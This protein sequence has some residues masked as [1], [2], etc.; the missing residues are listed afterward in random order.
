MCTCPMLKRVLYAC[1]RNTYWT[2]LVTGNTY[3]LLT[4]SFGLNISVVHFRHMPSEKYALWSGK[5]DLCCEPSSC[6]SYICSPILP[7]GCVL[8][9]LLVHF[10]HMLSE[11]S[12]RAL[13]GLMTLGQVIISPNFCSFGPQR[14][15][16]RN[17]WR[18]KNTNLNLPDGLWFCICN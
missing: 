1:P 3:L 17:I 7:A 8:Q 18:R 6:T 14:A 16:K 12:R 5:L 10:L 11:N 13:G 4:R 15:D 9:T 2:G